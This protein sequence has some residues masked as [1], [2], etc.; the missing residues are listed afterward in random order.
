MEA[1]RRIFG[2]AIFVDNV[3]TGAFPYA[4][5]YRRI[6]TLSIGRQ[7]FYSPRRVYGDVSLKYYS[8]KAEGKEVRRVVFLSRGDPTLDAN[9]GREAQALKTAGFSLEVLTSGAML[10]REDVR[11]DLSLFD[12]VVI[13]VDAVSE[14]LWR[15][16]LR[17][18]TLLNYGKVMEGIRTFAREYD[19][20]LTGVLHV[21][22]GVD[23]SGE[24]EVVGEFLKEIGVR[25]VFVLPAS[26][27]V[28]GVAERLEGLGLEVEVLQPHLS[29][30][31]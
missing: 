10:W 31:G 4:P 28:E 30:E 6:G 13:T 16:F 12:R 27:D 15:R 14:D 7:V 29:G 23:Y 25:K 17:P 2:D 18:H 21:I 24:G 20:D 26:G 3:P 11:R 8:L 1:Y 22:P 5:T 19:G 9:L